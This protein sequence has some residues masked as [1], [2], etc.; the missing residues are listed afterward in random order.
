VQAVR[1][2]KSLT[3]VLAA[4][5]PTAAPGRAGAELS[6]PALAGQRHRGRARA[7]VPK[8]PP[9]NVD[10][11]LLTALALLWPGPATRRPTPTTRWWTRP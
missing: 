8:P 3:D 11:L 7:L 9:P 5:R 2:G 1:G 10:A 4:C 6:T